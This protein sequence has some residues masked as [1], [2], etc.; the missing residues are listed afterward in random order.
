MDDI[1]NETSKIE[2]LIR[3]IDMEVAIIREKIETKERILQQIDNEFVQTSGNSGAMNALIEEKNGIDRILKKWKV[4][5]NSM[6][7]ITRKLTRAVERSEEKQLR[8]LLDGTLE[9]FNHLTGNQYITKIDD[10]VVLQ[11]VTRNRVSEDITPPVI[12]A[13]L[14]SLKFSLSDFII[15]GSTTI[16]LLIDEPFQFM[17]DE[18]C[19]RFRDLVSYIS[20]K[21]Q[22]IIFTHQSD[23][24]NWG[25]F[26]EL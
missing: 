25:N 11:M 7:F 18:R 14:M 26:I 23:K 12:H 1:E 19:N 16:P 24:R 5:R 21:R 2:D 8:K 10:A 20:K 13:L 6:Q 9:K 15:S 3:N 22:V 17:D 4:N